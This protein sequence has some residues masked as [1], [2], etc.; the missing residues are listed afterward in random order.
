[1][2]VEV[3]Y[4]MFVTAVCISFLLS[5]NG[6]RIRVFTIR[7]YFPKVDTLCM[8]NK[9]GEV[10]VESRFRL[11]LMWQRTEPDRTHSTVCGTVW[12]PDMVLSIFSSL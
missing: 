5:R 3:W 7:K 4:V 11:V 8:Y 1:M 9:I 10:R 6:R 12:A 2:F